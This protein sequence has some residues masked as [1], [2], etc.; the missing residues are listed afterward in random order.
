MR[1]SALVPLLLAACATTR[2]APDWVPTSQSYQAPG[3]GFSVELPEGWMRFNFHRSELLAISRDGP[4]LQRIYAGSSAVGEPVGMGR[5]KRVV[6]EGMTPQQAAELVIDDIAATSDLTEVVVLENAPATLSGRPGF[7]VLTAYREDGLKV[8]T[9]VVG[10]IAEGRFFFL[11]YVAPER[12]YFAL[13]EPTFEDLVRSFRI[14][15]TTPPSK[16]AA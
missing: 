10:A 6:R 15:A 5:S 1:R 4:Q 7:R 14:L 12:H 8:R 13:D 9:A 16:P 2:P 11:L 3:M